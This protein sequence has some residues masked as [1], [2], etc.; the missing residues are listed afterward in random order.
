[1]GGWW[2]DEKWW[3]EGW[4]YTVWGENNQEESEKEIIKIII[5]MAKKNGK[6]SR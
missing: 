5:I 2:Y 3:L 6:N 4:T 1:M